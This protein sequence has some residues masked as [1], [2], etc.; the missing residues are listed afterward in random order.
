MRA[1]PHG[2][3][4][5]IMQA[6]AVILCNTLACFHRLLLQLSMLLRFR[7]C[8][9]VCTHVWHLLQ[10]CYCRHVSG[11][12]V[13]MR[14]NQAL[15]PQQSKPVCEFTFSNVMDCTHLSLLVSAPG[16]LEML[17]LRF[18]IPSS[19]ALPDSGHCGENGI[20]EEVL[21]SC[22]HHVANCLWFA[23]L[24]SEGFSPC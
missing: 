21:N 6:Y 22:G 8:M 10:W 3:E 11:T 16:Q 9:C 14:F 12:C 1:W 4:I 5:L 15:R 24:C 7:R 17:S 23:Q 2:G 19:S 20:A 18:Q 13:P